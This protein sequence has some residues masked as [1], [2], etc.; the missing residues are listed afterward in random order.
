[1]ATMAV[2]GGNACVCCSCLLFVALNTAALVHRGT[3]VINLI[4]SDILVITEVLLIMGLIKRFLLGHERSPE[5]KKEGINQRHS[6]GKS[7][8]AT[9]E[10]YP[11]K[12]CL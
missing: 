2:A 1:M 4:M 7:L 9:A 12:S 3:A 6:V 5:C 11:S 8:W 10:T